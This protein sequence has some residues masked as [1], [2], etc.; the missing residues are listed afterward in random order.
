MQMK[1]PLLAVYLGHIAATRSLE[2]QDGWWAGVRLVQSLAVGQEIGGQS[3]SRKFVEVLLLCWK[4]NQF[5]SVSFYLFV[6]DSDSVLLS[7]LAS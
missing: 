4:D 6:Q 2:K 3:W 5:F 1:E 7:L